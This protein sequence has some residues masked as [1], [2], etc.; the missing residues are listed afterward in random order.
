VQDG[1][2]ASTRE[3]TAQRAD[4]D[5]RLRALGYQPAFERAIGLWQNF[6]LGFTYLS[7]VVGVYTL[8]AISLATGGPP[9]FWS[10]VIVGVGQFLVCLVFAEIV[11]E[12]PLAG[13]ILPWARRLAGERWAWM[14][15]WIYLCALW[16]T[17]AAVCV[18]AAPF[19]ASL[20][21]MP[22]V[23]P[24]AVAATALLLILVATLLNLASTRLLA[25]I[26]M[27]GF[28]AELVGALAVGGY[29]LLFERVQPIGILFDTFDISVDGR[30]WPAF[31]AAA[32][33][34]VFQYY[35]FEA[36]GDLAEEVPDPSRQIP[37]A[38]RMTIYVGGAAA[39]FACLAFILAVPDLRAVV[40]GADKD[41]IGTILSK[42]FGPVGARLVI[43]VV[44][45]SF[46][47]CVL[48]LQAAASR[49]LFAFGRDGLIA[50]AK[51]F[52]S[53]T[54]RTR[55]PSAALIACGVLPAIVVLIGFAKQDALTQIISFAA[56]GIYIAFQMVV[57]A[58]LRARLKGWVPAGAFRLGAWGT[59]VNVL[60]LV[61]GIAAIINIGWPRTPD[62]P[63]Y[64]DYGT[65]VS[66]L[67]VIG[68]GLVY[69]AVAHTNAEVRPHPASRG[70]EH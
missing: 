23:S 70:Q 55:L 67:V 27:F 38:M 52:G 44:G 42:A 58:A 64:L 41:P 53:V 22:D 12:F 68:A 16:T 51:T 20:A 17:I 2:N 9:M 6:A 50:G 40:S 48:S 39:M 37:K 63:W 62:Q 25:R 3:V 7:P 30:Y 69:L 4:D 36:C 66:T 46:L 21:G 34:G 45:I 24:L 49:L 33:A 10:Y 29:L 31:L 15:G 60:A 19:L 32:L 65:I 61:Y 14:A 59:P 57:I 56:I 11:S 28:I 47:S 35:G 18:G 1:M 54:P 5:A 8:F 43:F 13:G 26:A